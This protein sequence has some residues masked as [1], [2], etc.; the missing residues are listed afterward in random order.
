VVII[1]DETDLLLFPPLRAAWTRRGETV[2]VWLTGW[3]A[4]RV[5]FGALELGTGQRVLLIREHQR[6]EDFQ[7][8]LKE[9]RA[10]YSDQP[11]VL[12]LDEDTS[13]KAKA[14]VALAEKLNIR[15]LWLPKR[16]PELNPM[17]SLWRHAKDLISANRQYNSIEEQAERFV[18]YI[19][20][21]TKDEALNIAGV[22]S[23]HFWLRS[24][25]SNYFLGL[26]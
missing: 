13:H 18:N 10:L 4:R 17:E 25:M 2:Q 11:I 21:L 16:A 5:I 1:V 8:L 3:N 24:A 12:L 14:S 19:N 9:L 6:S 7:A 26:A 15:L 22:R 20:S 23:P